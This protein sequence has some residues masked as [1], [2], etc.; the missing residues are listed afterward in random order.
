M[1]ERHKVKA[2]PAGKGVVNGSSVEEVFTLAEIL[3]A[4]YDLI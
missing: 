2:A 3:W 4:D 1:D